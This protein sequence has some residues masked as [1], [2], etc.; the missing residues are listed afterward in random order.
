LSLVVAAGAIGV[1][2][3]GETLDKL[4]VV[5]QEN[6]ASPIPYPCL[7]CFPWFPPFICTI[8]EACGRSQGL[9]PSPAPLPT[10]CSCPHR[11]P[12]P[13]PLSRLQPRSHRRLSPKLP[14][15]RSVGPQS[16]LQLKWSL[17]SFPR[18]PQRLL[19]WPLPWSLFMLPSWPSLRSLGV[20]YGQF[21]RKMPKSLKFVNLS[22]ET[23]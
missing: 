1:A 11:R 17:R 16:R 14:L 15:M 12:L 3:A 4:R 23:A 22:I 8:C 5:G 9:G 13:R 20:R 18:S 19:L 21:S 2:V 6:S 7:P 10:R